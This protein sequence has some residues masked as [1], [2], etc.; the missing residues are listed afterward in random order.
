VV[1]IGVPVLL[2]V[3]FESELLSLWLPLTALPYYWLY[4]RDLVLTGYDKKDILS[5]YALNLILIPV[6]LSGV[7][8]SFY[9]ILT[10]VRAPFRR[11]PKIRGR[12]LTPSK[13]VV[14]ECGML[15]YCLFILIVDVF[16]QRW[17][18][19]IFAFVNG[20]LL[21]YAIFK[22]IFV[23]E[24]MEDVFYNIFNYKDKILMTKY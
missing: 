9:Q 14:I 24:S 11:T 12:T 13:F 7:F 5:V 17:A 22:F 21:S 15:A 3:P 2:L 8:R 6:N 23:K 18:H 10:G 19:G 16:S 20:C 4:T 1:N